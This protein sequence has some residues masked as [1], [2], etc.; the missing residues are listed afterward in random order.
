MTVNV[1]HDNNRES[2]AAA[3]RESEERFSKAFHLSPIGNMLVRRRDAIIV[4]VN[5]AYL[6]ILGYQ[7]SELVGEHVRKLRFFR[8]EELRVEVR[9]AYERGEG[10]VGREVSF[11]RR[12][13][14]VGHGIYSNHLIEIGGEHFSLG[15]L[16]DITGR[17]QTEQSLRDSTM[18]LQA[19]LAGGGM[20]TWIW[21]ITSGAV[22]FDDAAV[23]LWGREREELLN[24]F[25]HDTLRCVH[26]DDRSRLQ[27]AFSAFAQSIEIPP[28][29]FRTARPDGAL[30]WI[31]TRG[32][33]ERDADGKPVRVAGVFVDTTLR[34]KMEDAQL[35][36]QKME[37]LGTLAGGVAHDFNN[38]LLAISGN[39]RL[40]MD[41]LPGGHP[42]QRS[43]AEIEKASG[44]ASDL[45]RR[46]LTFSRQ[47]DGKRI[48]VQLQPIVEEALRLMRPAIPTMVEIKTRMAMDVPSVAVDPIQIHQV[49]M[50]LTANAAHA[51]GSRGGLIEL[52]L[53]GLRITEHNNQVSL[54]LSPGR[55][56]RLRVTDDGPGMDAQTRER[57]FDPFFTTKPVGQG[58]GLG[59]SVVHG[60]VENLGGAI[61]VYSQPGKGTAFDLYFPATE[62]EADEPGQSIANV[63]SADGRHVMYVDDEE[64]LVFL[65]TRALERQGYR[66]TGHTSPAQA[67]LD[68]SA[69]PQAFDVVVTDLSM[70]GM[71][72]I[73]LATELMKV[74]PDIP[75]LLTS[76]YIR[77]EDREAARVCGIRDFIQKPHTMGE[78]GPV[79]KR[80]FE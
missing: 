28:I 3:L 14:T 61:S 23:K 55:Y 24:C 21:D 56:A 11:P 54:Q 80:L 9:A 64:A 44:R 47:Q 2:L 5:S 8:Q 29:E 79:L 72:G 74:R 66:V 35:Q 1:D 69:N 46:I 4:E 20:G 10:I 36:S 6:N 7:R 62:P 25:L 70:V 78:L 39:A 75:V 17:K 51:I 26:P 19:T 42:A 50:N 58:T 13:E 48:V 30:Q 63:A 53:D 37:A 34:R 57:I 22:S 76:G 49:I 60:I 32:Q 52:R 33:I 38:I 59:L 15:T 68:F 27:D 73:V 71:T 65:A 12:D 16:I 40:A 31:S 18:R 67:L 43:L 41:D 45:V 77:A